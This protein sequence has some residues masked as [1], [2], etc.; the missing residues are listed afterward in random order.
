MKA[1]YL[2][3]DDGATVV[4]TPWV[5]SSYTSTTRMPQGFPAGSGRRQVVLS[6]LTTTGSDS[7]KDC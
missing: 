1:Y 3:H 6:R 2:Q 7:A 5:L 4:I